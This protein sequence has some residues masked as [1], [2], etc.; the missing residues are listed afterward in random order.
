MAGLR[1]PAPL[2]RLGVGLAEAGRVPDPVLRAAIRG[3]CAQRLREVEAGDPAGRDDRAVRFAAWMGEQPLA[4]VPEKANQQ[5]YEVPPA[6]FQAVLGAR[7][8][9]SSCLFEPGVRSLDEA[10]ERML[11]LTVA[12]AGLEDGMRVLDL[13]CGWG[14]LSLWL[15]EHHP[16]SRIVAVSNSKDQREWILARAQRLGL[17]GLEVRTADMNDFEPELSA[18]RFDRVVSVEMFEHMRNWPALFGRVARWLTPEGR[19]FLHVFCHR[20][21]PYAFEDQGEGDW[22]SRTFFSGG[23]MPSEALPR[24]FDRDLRV[25]EQ[26][27]VGGLHYRA[28]ADAWLAR[29]DA[30]KEALAPVLRGAYGEQGPLWHQRWRLFFIAVSELFGYRRGEEWFVAHTLL[31]PAA[32]SGP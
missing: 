6:F 4:V 9:Y 3:L 20:D 16:R 10:E 5:H 31:R 26:W 22:M 7:L 27:R 11:A 8:K 32:G 23:I 2:I 19:F 30:A 12:R 13:G 18:G 17:D 21:T 24:R 25:E 28:T 14:S 15:A 1:L 29:L